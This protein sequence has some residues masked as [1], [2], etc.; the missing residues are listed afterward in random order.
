MNEQISMFELLGETE[1]PK[2][3][4][5]E[6]K[7]GRKGWIIE[8]SGLFL[9]KNGFKEDHIGVCTHAIVFKEN[10]TKDK[11][12]RISQYVEKI[13]PNDGG[14]WGPNKDV[15]AARPTMEE[16][17]AYAHSRYTIPE[18]VVYYERD[19]RDRSI[20]NYEEGNKRL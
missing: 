19:G 20:R 4:F 2:I 9:I 10:S 6:Q 14:W 13:K 12:G 15:Y 5:E 7:K 11:Y 3:P 17:I 8:I 16:C 18:K 1:T